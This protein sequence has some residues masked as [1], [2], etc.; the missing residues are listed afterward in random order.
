MT[1]PS[2]LSG[3]TV[4][5]SVRPTAIAPPNPLYGWIVPPQGHY[6]LA[7]ALV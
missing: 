4:E 3:L 1:E 2:A 6:V 7:L 5:C